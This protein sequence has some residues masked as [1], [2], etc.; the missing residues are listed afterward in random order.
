MKVEIIIRS[1]DTV[2]LQAHC[3]QIGHPQNTGNLWKG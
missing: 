1:T 3:Y 2:Y